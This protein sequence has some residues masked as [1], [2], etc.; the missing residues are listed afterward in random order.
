[1]DIMGVVTKVMHRL[2]PAWIPKWQKE[3]NQIMHIVLYHDISVKYLGEFVCRR[4]RKC[5]NL[6]HIPSSHK[7]STNFEKS[8][9][10][11]AMIFSTQVIGTNKTTAAGNATHLFC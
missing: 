4:A 1:M 3:V 9:S 5:S 11:K 2:P 7:S 8:A 10:R 6:S